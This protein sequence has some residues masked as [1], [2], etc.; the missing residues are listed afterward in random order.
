L[1]YQVTLI[2]VTN[3]LTDARTLPSSPVVDCTSTVVFE[4]VEIG[5]RYGARI[6]AFDR[7]GLEAESEGSPTVVDEDGSEVLPSWTTLCTGYDGEIDQ[8]LGG[9]G[10][11]GGEG[12]S[13]SN[14][15]LGVLAIEHAAVPIR[16]CAPLSGDF[17]PELTGITVDPASFL[18]SLSCGGEPGE[19]FD[20]A[21]SLPA[22]D[23]AV[24]GAG[25]LGG[26]GGAASGR[27]AC[28]A[29]LTRRGLEPGLWVEFDVLAYEA[30]QDEPSWL[31]SCAARTELGTLIP[32]TCGPLRPL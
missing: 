31:A 8:A 9:A 7:R 30:D 1:S 19:V 3:G 15:S 27:T 6:A 29:P 32:A 4:T 5:H 11:A 10:G 18:G 20:Y 12:G 16:G 23:V 13:F 24:G 28:T 17:D 26:S 14:R 21:A 2:D 22:E 25:G